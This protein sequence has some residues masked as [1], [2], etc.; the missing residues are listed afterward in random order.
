[1]ADT[2]AYLATYQQSAATFPDTGDPGPGHFY[3]LS[4]MTSQ[5]LGASAYFQEVGKLD[6]L[7]IEVDTF[8]EAWDAVWKDYV[9]SGRG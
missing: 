2:D 4:S 6:R 7:A 1:M 5:F 3:G 8:R 9:E